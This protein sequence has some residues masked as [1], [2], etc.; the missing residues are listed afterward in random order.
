MCVKSPTFP[1]FKASI[2]LNLGKLRPEIGIGSN[3][4]S[5]GGVFYLVPF[6]FN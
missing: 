1:Y 6:S 5:N 2:L 3:G 4:F